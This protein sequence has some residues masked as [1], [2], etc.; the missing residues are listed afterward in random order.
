MNI[1]LKNNP[2]I[3]K[4]TKKKSRFWSQDEMVELVTLVQSKK[5]I[6]EG[7]KKAA[8]HF[9]VTAMAI[10]VRY[11]RYI[12]KHS[13]TYIDKGFKTKKVSVVTKKR[14]PYKK[15]VKKNYISA[16]IDNGGISKMEGL[17]VL[18]FNIRDVKIDLA[19]SK[20][21]IFY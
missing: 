7:L 11:Y 10:Q 18:S 2:M 1:N 17:R 6:K 19:S 8:A 14:K 9:N 15:H 4:E 21:M 5:N 20:L 12:K 3:K 16:I 13:M